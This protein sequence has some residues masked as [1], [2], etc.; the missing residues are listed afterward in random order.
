VTHAGS[1]IGFL[2]RALDRSVKFR[3]RDL[4]RA[5]G[6]RIALLA[7]AIVTVVGV[8]L[9]PVRDSVGPANVAVM[10]AIVVGLAGSSA[11]PASGIATGIW[12]ALT[13]AMLH[14]VPHGLPTVEEGQ[15]A[16]TAL[17]L[18]LTGWISGLVNSRLT[19]AARRL[20]RVDDDLER[21][22]RVGEVAARRRDRDEVIGAAIE[23]V[24]GELRLRDAFLEHG[25]PGGKWRSLGRNGV[26]EGVPSSAT[27]ARL[28]QVLA[29]GV[30]VE[31]NDSS[32][33]VLIGD[34][35]VEI[36]PRQLHVAIALAD[37]MIVVAGLDN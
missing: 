16:L 13:F 21:L 5:P 31:I 6:V 3:A 23:E 7:S 30:A 25:P 8:A 1:N 26:I 29:D 9:T 34:P 35:A 2:V 20:E 10:F 37:Y 24:M 22:S 19:S 4:F 17:L 11:G 28:G 33:L 12:A 14:S 36:E 32:R 15:D 27:N 18:L